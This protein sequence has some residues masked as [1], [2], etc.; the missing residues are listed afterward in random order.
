[1]RRILTALAVLFVLQ[2]I[3]SGC[4]LVDPD[5]YH[6]EHHEW[7]HDEGHDRD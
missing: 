5:D 2:V 4:V 1:M 6:R 3:F 7:Y